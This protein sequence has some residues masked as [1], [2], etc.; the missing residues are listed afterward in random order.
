MRCGLMGVEASVSAVMN[1]KHLH[2]SRKP[3]RLRDGEE[4]RKESECPALKL[5]TRDLTCYKAWS[6]KNIAS[7]SAPAPPHYTYH[8]HRYILNP[9]T[10]AHTLAQPALF[11]MFVLLMCSTSGRIR[12]NARRPQ[13]LRSVVLIRTNHSPSLAR[14]EPGVPRERRGERGR[15]RVRVRMSDD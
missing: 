14:A 9:Y 2:Y 3:V 15:E 10:Y 4:G 13:A 12:L 8:T 11:K 5:A 7:Q 6:N 1:S